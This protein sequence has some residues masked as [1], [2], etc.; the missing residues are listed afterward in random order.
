M[1]GIPRRYTYEEEDRYNQFVNIDT[2]L[3][4]GDSQ[5]VEVIANSNDRIDV[6]DLEYKEVNIELV[7]NLSAFILIGH[8]A[9]KE[10]IKVY[11]SQTKEEYI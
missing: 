5:N 8:E 11:Y 9:L 2:E 1:L 6:G 7:Y 3:E 10:T 4:G